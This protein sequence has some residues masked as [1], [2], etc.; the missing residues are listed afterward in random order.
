MMWKFVRIQ[1]LIYQ[2]IMKS[3]KRI[4]SKK[5]KKKKFGFTLQ[6]RLQI[7]VQLCIVTHNLK[8]FLR[9]TIKTL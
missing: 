4:K 3:T 9:L 8:N 6:Y 5:K 7:I 1:K 2:I